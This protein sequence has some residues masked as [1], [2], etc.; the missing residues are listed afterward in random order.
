[1]IPGMI[2]AAGRGERMR[3][4]TDRVPKP[5][6]EVGGRTLI[7][8]QL[9]ALVRGGVTQIVINTAHL[10]EQIPQ[11]LGDGEAWGAQLRY[12]PEPPGAL[13]TAGG[14]ATAQPWRS[15]VKSGPLF[16]LANA[17][18]YSDLNWAALVQACQ[19][20]WPDGAR[21]VLVVVPNPVHHP[22]GD[23]VLQSEGLSRLLLL[24]ETPG[25]E[26]AGPVTYAGLGVFHRDLF[27]DCPP[28]QRAA[29]GPLLREAAAK[30]SLWGWLHQGV[31]VDVGTP[32]RLA[33][34]DARLK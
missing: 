30:G 4:L 2:L 28:G 29:L 24:P 7:A 20:D 32:E 25:P 16:A 17:D 8:W 11:A 9:E 1:M 14:I 18:V 5:L 15:A 3:P 19:S 33:A 22:R 23:F 31:W 34:L 26:A 13:E 10:G 6:L 21:A 27:A 12:S